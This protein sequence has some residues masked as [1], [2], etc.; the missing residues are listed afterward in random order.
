[1]TNAN[2]GDSRCFV[3]RDGKALA[4]SDDHKPSRPSEKSRII[5]AKGHVKPSILKQAGF[6]LQIGPE[7]VWPGGLSVSR[8]FGD[9]NLKSPERLIHEFQQ[10]QNRHE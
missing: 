5:R 9:H 10:Y 8:G 6:R 3:I 1:M 2:A 7:R 4:V